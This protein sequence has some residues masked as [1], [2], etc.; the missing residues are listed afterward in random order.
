MEC[1]CLVWALEILNYH[2]DGSAFRAITDCNAM[3]SHLNMKAP[4]RHMLRW[5][6][7]IQEYRGNM[8]I[9]YKAGK[10]HKNADGL[11]RRALANTPDNPAYLA[12]EEEPQITI[13]GIN[14]IDIGSEFFEEVRESFKQDKN[15]HILTSLL[16]KECK[17]T[18]LVNALDE[19]CKNSSYERRFDLCDGIIYHITKHLCVMTLC[20]RLLMNTILH[21]CH[22]SICSGHFSGDR[23][24]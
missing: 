18:S 16:D 3:K 6:I 1:L 8:N 23:K 19:I 24:L 5:Q 17:D 15:C 2:L 22:Y 7:A 14:I 13:E 9:V 20:I 4:N 11:S 12:L 10:M 21:R